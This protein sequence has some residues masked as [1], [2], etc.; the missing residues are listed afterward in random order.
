MTQ[1]QEKTLFRQ[2]FSSRLFFII[3]LVLA[4]FTVVSYA[5]GYWQDYKVKQEIA[6]LKSEV[7]NLEKKKIESLEI[8][9]YVTS[10]AFVE[11]KARTELNMKKPGEKV[12][13]IAG[14][15]IE[16]ANAE[17]PKIDAKQ[18]GLNNP[19][20]WWYYFFR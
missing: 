20:K 10:D 18:E 6:S 12:V 1:K 16:S 5:R 8:L 15:K 7:S 14:N 9:Q 3:A 11:E 4:I 2:F 19:V 13:V 17:E